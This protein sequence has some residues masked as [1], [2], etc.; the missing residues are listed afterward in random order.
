MSPIRIV[1]AI[2]TDDPQELT[3][4]RDIMSGVVDWVQV[5]IMDGRFVPSRSIGWEEIRDA[6]LPFGW[7]AHLM[8]E[9][10]VDYFKGFKAAGAE[11]VI[12]HYETVSDPSTVTVAAREAGLTVGMAVNPETSVEDICQWLDSLDHVLLMSVHPGFYGA[13]FLPE[14]LAKIEQLRRYAPGLTIGIDGGIKEENLLE[15]ASRGVDDICV[16]SGVFRATDPAAAFQR[17]Q[18]MVTSFPGA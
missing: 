2:L 9:N 18:A 17:L 6:R 8:V 10:P 3:A 1:P 12:F 13:K 5:D 7:E 11:R 14:V 4:M 16:G 15:V